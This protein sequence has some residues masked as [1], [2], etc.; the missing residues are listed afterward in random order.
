MSELYI[1]F[2][3]HRCLCF[4]GYPLIYDIFP[5][6]TGMPQRLLLSIAPTLAEMKLELQ[7][8]RTRTPSR[9]IDPLCRPMWEV[10]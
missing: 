7:G 2:I 9:A 6:L 5:T 3:Y 10:P 8:S 1:F 4:L